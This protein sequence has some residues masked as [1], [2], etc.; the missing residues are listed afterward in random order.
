MQSL[1]KTTEIEV[2]GLGKLKIQELSAKAYFEMQGKPGP[3]AL[4]IVC[5]YGVLDW[6]GETVDSVAAAVP[7]RLLSEIGLK[8]YEL[9]GVDAAKNSEPTQSDGSSSASL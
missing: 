3:D 6:N 7:M 4:A 8:V 1:L 5:K 2:A 9:S